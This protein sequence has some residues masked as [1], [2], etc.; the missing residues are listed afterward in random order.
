MSRDC[1]LQLLA[2]TWVLLLVTTAF[3]MECPRIKVG[4][5]N[6]CIRSGPGCA[7]CKTPNFTKAGEP[8]SIRCDTIEQLLQRGCLRDEIEFPVNDI[9]RTRD[10]PLSNDIQLTPQEVHLKLRIGQPAVFEVKFRRATGYPIDLYYLM[11][12][13]YSMLDDLEKVKK[14][15][16]ELL[17]ALESTTPYRRI[18]F[19]SFVDKTVLPFVNTHP[20]KL[21]NP[22]PNKNKQ[23][24][25]PFAFKHILSLTDDAAKFE[26]EVG[27]QFISGNLDAP[28]GGLDAMMQA[29]VCGDLIGWR[30]VT[31]LLVY[32]TDDGFHFAGD[33]KLAAILTPNDGQ[34]HLEDNMYKKSNE[35]DYP[36]VGQLVQKLTENNIQP[37]FAV[38]SKM[39]D[40]YKKLSELI[41]KSAVGELNEDSSNII[42]LIQVAYNNLSSRIILE[43]SAL[44]DVLDVKYDSICSEKNIV[45]DE[46]RGECDN[47]K[48]NHEITFRVKVV[49]KECIKRQS[50]TIRPL[51]FTDT[52]TVHLDSNCDCDCGE[53][54]DP[55]ACS[56]KGTVVCGICRYLLSHQNTVGNVARAGELLGEGRWAKPRAAAWCARF[57]QAPLHLGNMGPERGRCDCGECKCTPQYQGSACQCKKSLD[58]CLNNKGNECSLRGSC[59]C[60]RCQCRGEYQPPLCQECP[61]CPSPCGTYV[62]C[63][64]CRAFQSGPFEKNCSQACPNIRLVEKLTEESKQCRE[65]DSNNCWISF[66][67]VQEDG[68]EMYSVTFDPEKECPEPPNIALIVGSTVAGVALIGLLLL[69]LWRLL[70]ELFDRREYR[71]FEKEKSKAKWNDA[72][73]PLFKSA[74]TTVVNPRFN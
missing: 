21:Q 44:P 38:T 72:D 17:R 59:H 69:L 24:Q 68:D 18:G 16:G 45:M 58:G 67:M 7:W 60:N 54:R 31:R 8:D 23:C 37:I 71:R 46:A 27:K 25:P 12:L 52:L 11:D 47:V 63:V 13:S 10:S 6:D 2:V 66:Q 9:T 53:Q 5:C 43:H 15:G 22:C 65:K 19:G 62:S 1:C 49:A 20:E 36:S 39:V 3:A 33:G 34:C 48:I 61:S 35:F 4:T 51:G 64:E 28:E 70:M 14:L 57:L 30:N 29:A 41:P 73:N 26:S 74:T 55:A 50:F 32:A 40:V 42:E 56:G